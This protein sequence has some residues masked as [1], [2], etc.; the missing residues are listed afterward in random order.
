MVGEDIT[1]K[2]GDVKDVIT[3]SPTKSKAWLWKLIL[4]LIII[5]FVL[6]LFTHPEVIR[7]FTNKYFNNL[8]S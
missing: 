6:Y 5:G 4:V 8:L 2:I 7:D 3:P 1:K